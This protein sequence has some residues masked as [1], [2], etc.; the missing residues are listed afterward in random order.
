VKCYHRSPEATKILIYARIHE[1]RRLAS[2]TTQIFADARRCTTLSGDE[3]ELQMLK[4]VDDYRAD[5]ERPGQGR[6]RR[7][8][9]QMR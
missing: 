6:G 7:R 3:I 2:A 1:L 9:K 5:H 4:L 8:T